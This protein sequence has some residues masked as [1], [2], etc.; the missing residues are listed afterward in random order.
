MVQYAGLG[1]QVNDREQHVRAGGRVDL[2]TGKDRV[3]RTR[4]RRDEIVF[5]RL[6]PSVL[7]TRIRDCHELLVASVSRCYELTRVNE[8]RFTSF[9]LVHFF[10]HFIELGRTTQHSVQESGEPLS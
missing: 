10:E 4:S 8:E 7:E 2:D 5:Y 3:P 1:F 6:Q 9:V